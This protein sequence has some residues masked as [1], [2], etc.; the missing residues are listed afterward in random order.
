MQVIVCGAGQVGSNI[1]RYLSRFDTDV[2][3]IDIDPA[4]ISAATN[5]LDVRGIVGHAG[6]PDVLKS[7][8]AGDADLII[9]K[10]GSRGRCH[11]YLF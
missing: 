1:A 6:H 4:L 8:G 2:T 9:A 3:M 7:A 10:D 5:N 11:C